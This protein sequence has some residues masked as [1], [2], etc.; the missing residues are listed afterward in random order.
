MSPSDDFYGKPVIS[1]RV[2]Q[3]SVCE[4]VLS[5]SLVLSCGGLSL[6]APQFSMRACVQAR[7]CSPGVSRFP[8]AC[9]CPG[10]T[11]PT[12]SPQETR[13]PRLQRAPGRWGRPPRLCG[14]V[15]F[16]L[17]PCWPG[18]PLQCPLALKTSFPVLH[19]VTWLASFSAPPSLGGLRLPA[20]WLSAAA[21]P[22][23]FHLLTMCWD[24]PP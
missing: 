2:A 12:A 7:L 10:G 24:N 17:S 9:C 6:R 20:F 13:G 5:C 4:L 23:S 3:R 15:A 18:P 21:P 8:R 1:V 22:P 11:Q 19:Q 14:A 16:S